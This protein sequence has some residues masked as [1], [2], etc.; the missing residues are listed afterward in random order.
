MALSPTV[1]S[2]NELSPAINPVWRIILFPSSG[3]T[4]SVMKWPRVLPCNPVPSRPSNFACLGGEEG[5]QCGFN[6][7]QPL[8]GS[9]DFVTSHLPPAPDHLCVAPSSPCSGCNFISCRATL[10]SL[11]CRPPSLSLSPPTLVCSHSSS[12]P[13]PLLP[14]FFS[15]SAGRKKKDGG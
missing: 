6:P 10:Q 9:S 5:L 11:C 13:S 4:L 1:G 12:L 8:L 2:A 7:T 15:C 3:Q 14:I